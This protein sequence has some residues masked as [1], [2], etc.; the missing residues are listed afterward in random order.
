M[1]ILLVTTRFPL[2][3]WR[4]QQVR[5]VEWL[6]ALDQHQL[7]CVCPRPAV[8]KGINVTGFETVRFAM[9]GDSR[10]SRIGAGL[11]RSGIGSMP[12]QE[13]MYAT[14]AAEAAV[15]AAM[16][17]EPPDLVIIQMVRCSWVADLIERK[18]P[19]T[20]ILFDAIDAMGLHFGRA[21]ETFN[22]LVRPF[23]RIE[24]GR[25]RRREIRLAST[26]SV[27]V[28]VAERDLE[29]LGVPQG[30]GV[31]IPVSGYFSEAPR[32]PAPKPTV[33]L[34]G[35]LGYRPTVEAAQWFASV[36]WPRL[37]DS[38]PEA[39]WVLAGARPARA[40]RALASMQGVELHADVEDLGPFMAEAWVAIAPM[41]SGS[42]VPMKVLEAWAAGVPVVVHPWT[43]AGLDGGVHG[44]LRQAEG[45]GEWIEALVELLG[46]PDARNHLAES[47]RNAWE[48][49]YRPEVVS[50]QIREAVEAACGV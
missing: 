4:G 10:V 43:A 30:R 39:R 6:K 18:A 36:V 33:L 16:Q 48:R 15:Q 38:V 7:T 25:C 49:A 31:A 19:G 45:A 27:S 42:G 32:E 2:P 11:M 12:L 35:N 9:Y 29:E 17:T 41:S 8:V 34:S 50:E 26:A 40:I 21:A 13:G 47:G 37:K 23:A 46:N 3:A 20:P 22:A 1:R 24:A 14:R 28:A 44:A 5:T